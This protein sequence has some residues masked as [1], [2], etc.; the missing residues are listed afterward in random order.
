MLDRARKSNLDSGSSPLLGS[1]F[2][3]HSL[4]AACATHDPKAIL[5]GLEDVPVPPSRLAASDEARLRRILKR[6]VRGKMLLACSGS[7]DALVPYAWSKPLLDLLKDASGSWL[8][9]A[10]LVVEERLYPGAGHE[11][12]N[13]MVADA[14]AFLVNA[15]AEGPRRG[16]HPGSRD[17]EEEE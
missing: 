7:E 11:F 5:F 12:S 9:D 8:R 17:E 16:L 1:K 6:R 4:V 14:V 15:V 2:L 13:E 3:P 10:G